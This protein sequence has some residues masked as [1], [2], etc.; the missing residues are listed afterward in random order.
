MTYAPGGYKTRS[1]FRNGVLTYGNP[2]A[3]AG[4]SPLTTG[5]IT[6][7]IVPQ[8]ARWGLSRGVNQFRTVTFAPPPRG[9]S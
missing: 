1:Y 3:I 8:V 4:G 5:V 6:T 9:P 2:S 7:T